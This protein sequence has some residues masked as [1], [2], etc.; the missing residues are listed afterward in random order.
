[1]TGAVTADL[2]RAVA[3]DTA[4]TCG[5]GHSAFYTDH[6]DRCPRSVS[7]A[8]LVA[9][10]VAAEPHLT[11][12]GREQLADAIRGLLTSGPIG[13]VTGERYIR[14]DLIRGVLDGAQPQPVGADAEPGDLYGPPPDDGDES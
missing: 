7:L 11:A 1:M 3:A 10:L 13:K 5:R 4:C 12:A 9:I 2:A 8:A 14:A 6:S